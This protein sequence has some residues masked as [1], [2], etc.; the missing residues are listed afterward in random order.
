MNIPDQ[1]IE[2]VKK[3]LDNPPSVS[4]EELEACRKSAL[5]TALP[6]ALTAAAI[7]AASANYVA[8]ANYADSDDS[9]IALPAYAAY[10]ADSAYVDASYVA[11]YWVKRY[12]KLAQKE[13]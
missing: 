9:D 4:Q 2:L 10:A 6:A 13:A 1:T 11:Q 5:A 3:W 12:E 8:D 7:D